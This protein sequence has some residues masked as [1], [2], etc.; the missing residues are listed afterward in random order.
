MLAL[1]LPASV[2]THIIWYR[3][4]WARDLKWG[5]NPGASLRPDLT[6]TDLKS[7]SPRRSFETWRQAVVG[8]SRPWTPAQ[9]EAATNLVETFATLR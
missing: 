6:S 3:D 8:Q 5:G 7:L 2:G 9:I 1:P 4:D